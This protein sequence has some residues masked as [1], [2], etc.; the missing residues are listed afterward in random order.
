[1]RMKLR[2]G[3][4][5]TPV[6]EVAVLLDERAGRYHQV[7]A[8]AALVLRSLLSGS[9]PDEAARDLIRAHPAATPTAGADIAGLIAQLRAAHL[10][11]EAGD[12]KQRR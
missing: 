6:G 2:T 8:T 5:L 7:N 1:V 10:I 12:R 9:G 11:V 3:V 4:T